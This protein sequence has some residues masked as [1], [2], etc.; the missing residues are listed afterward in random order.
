[1]K[2]DQPCCGVAAV[3]HQPIPKQHD[4]LT[5]IRDY[6]EDADCAVLT[7]EPMPPHLTLNRK[8]MQHQISP[9]PID[10]VTSTHD[11]SSSHGS[12]VIV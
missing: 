8:T 4:R 1:V 7:V 3:V 11:V 10:I 9:A 5:L 6:C 12:V 2:V